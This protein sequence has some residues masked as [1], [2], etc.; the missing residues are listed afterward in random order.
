ME[1]LIKGLVL[2]V[3]VGGILYLALSKKKY[4]QDNSG[5]KEQIIQYFKE[6]NATNVENGIHTKDLPEFIAKSSY[7]LLMV[8]DKTLLFKKGKYFLNEEKEEKNV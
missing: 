4:R 7:L 8:Q 5:S 6:K 3:C 2:L 1:F